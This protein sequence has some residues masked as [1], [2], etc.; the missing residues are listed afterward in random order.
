MRNNKESDPLG[1]AV[2]GSGYWGKN[3]V[4]NFSDLGVLRMICDKNEALLSSFKKDYPGVQ[5]CFALIDVLQSKE[6]DGII[7][8]TPVETHFTIA[9]EALMAGKHVYVEKPLVLN[10]TEGEE[11]IAIARKNNRI[12]MVGHL[13]QYHP[14]FIKIKELI[15]DGELGKINY[16]YSNRLNLG[17]IRREENIL[18]SFAPHDISMILSLVGER[19][20]WVKATGGNYLHRQIADVT[21][22]HLDFPSGT[23]AHIFV[24]WLHPFKEQKLVVVGDRKMAVFNDTLGWEDKLLLYPHQI[25]WMDNIPTPAKA[26]PERVQIPQA[27]PLRNE[28]EQFLESIISETPPV[29]DGREGLDVLAVLKASQKSMDN[30][31]QRISL[32]KSTCPADGAGAADSDK[33]ADYFVHDSVEI[34]DNCSIAK[35]VKIWHFSHILANTTIGENC[36]IGQ[37][38]VAGPDVTI[39]SNCKI[40]NNVSVYKGVTLEDGVFCGP[41]MVFTNICNPRAEIPKMDKVQPTL[42]RKGATLGANSTIVCGVTLGRYCLVGAGAVVTHDIQDHAMVVGNPANQIGW[43]CECGERLTDDLS[44]TQC[45]K[46]YHHTSFGLIQD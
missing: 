36:T 23:K 10:E 12:L 42:V 1:I 35:G 45:C 33:S 32:D 3:L 41:S 2:V 7:V 8:A 46:R 5:T 18:W 40:Q 27:E 30:H 39:A 25:K 34:D 31:G 16:I 44:C 19:P 22:T 4:R 38:V 17:K 37:N 24:S 15:L 13:L 6:I 29:T 20:S 28:C 9:R 14:V 26:D 21:V 43:V 11:L